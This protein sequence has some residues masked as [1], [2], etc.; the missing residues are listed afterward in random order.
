MS[1]PET[2]PFVLVESPFAGDVE[3]NVAYLHTALRDCLSRG[4]AP[5]ASHAFYVQILDDDIPAERQLGIDAGLAIGAF[6]SKTVVYIDRGI[7]QGMLYGI[8]NAKAAGR[9]IEYRSII[10]PA[11]SPLA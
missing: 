6:A 2:M 5:F 9:A 4:E 3:D 1:Q 7:S 10:P 11:D 8:Q